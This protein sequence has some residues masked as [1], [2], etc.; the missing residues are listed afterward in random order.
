MTSSRHFLLLLLLLGASPSFSHTE[1]EDAV[2]AETID[3]D[4]PPAHLKKSLPGAFA[5]IATIVCTPATQHIYAD[6]SWTWRFPGSYF[7]VPSIPA[8]SPA[9]SRS[10]PTG[11][12]FT[13]FEISELDASELAEKHKWFASNVVTYPVSDVP[14]KILKLVATN[15]LGHSLDAYF[16]FRTDQEGWVMLCAPECAPEY[17]FLMRKRN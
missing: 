9:P 11:R 14:A 13:G 16:G 8:F 6:K 2:V 5:G 1:G 15:D 17:L 10:E 4:H 7:D 12:F 3:C